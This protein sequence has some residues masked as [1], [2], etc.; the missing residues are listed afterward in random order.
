[1]LGLF[2]YDV[3]RQKGRLTTPVPPFGCRQ[4]PNLLK[5]TEC[6][7]VTTQSEQKQQHHSMPLVLVVL[8]G[9]ELLSVLITFL[10]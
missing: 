10:D 8:L 9:S 7:H 3:T 1:M 6:H 5:C 4:L 2:T